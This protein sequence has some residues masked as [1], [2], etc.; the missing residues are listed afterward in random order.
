[1]MKNTKRQR[2]A[3]RELER[4]ERRDLLAGDLVAGDANGDYYFDETDF[5]HA[6]QFGK[7]ETGDS[8]VW[9]E[10]DWN[11]DGVFDSGDFVVAFQKGAYLTGAYDPSAGESP[12]DHLSALSITGVADTT[13][14]YDPSGGG[15]AIGSSL[16][17]VT[18]VQLR[19]S[20]GGFLDGSVPG[21]F[22]IRRSDRLFWLHPSGKSVLRFQDALPTN[23]TETELLEDLSIDGSVLSGGGL[24]NVRLEIVDAL[25]AGFDVERVTHPN[26]NPAP[27]PD[28]PKPKP[29]VDGLVAGDANGD[30]YFDEADFIQTMK[31][32]KFETG[33]SASW[34]EGDW[35]EDGEHNSSDYVS[36]FVAGWYSR[37]AYNDTAGEPVTEL[38]PF[39]TT[40][41]ADVTVYY[42]STTGTLT[43]VASGDSTMTTL[44]FSSSSG[45]FHLDR[46]FPGLF[47]VS[48]ETSQFQLVPSGSN[49]LYV[50]GA[51]PTE[52]SL[53]ELRADLQVDGSL[54]GGGGLGTVVLDDSANLPAGIPAAPAP[55]PVNP[56]PNPNPENPA[57]RPNDSFVDI[58]EANALLT[59]DP[60]TGTSRLQASTPSLAH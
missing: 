37:G 45:Q 34:A 40:G 58:S 38:A 44:H 55:R 27:R 36:A 7:F 46:G 25:P 12:L 30:I 31:S 49:V 9:G 11:E 35:N 28:G 10:G 57:P 51:L 5:V 60:S 18:T 4:L 54:F 52:L 17:D 20:S 23:M 33:E 1:M 14:Y 50:S 59:Y 19:S 3:N 8:A 53:D 26:P 15:I 21:L 24:G 48:N 43:A 22:D 41:P 32:G 42:D 39:S 29:H 16:G 56:N 13:V 2:Y 6:F 47:D